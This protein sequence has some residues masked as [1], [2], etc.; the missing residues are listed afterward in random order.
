MSFAA[1]QFSEGELR[2]IDQRLLP[3]EQHWLSLHALEEVAIAIENMTVRGAPAIG[4]AAAFAVAMQARSLSKDS[5]TLKEQGPILMQGIERLKRTRPT[6]V[7]LFTALARMERVLGEIENT[8]P[9]SQALKA[10]ERAAQQ[11]FDDDLATCQAIGRWGASYINH[12]RPLHIITHCNTGSLATAGYGTALGIIRSLHAQGRVAMVYADE[13]RPWLQGARLTAFELEAE[14]IPYR[15]IADSAAAF[16][17]QTRPID[18]VVVGADRIAMNGDT[19]NKIGTYSL[20]VNARRHGIPFVVAAPRT[21][22]DRH[23]DS[24]REI[25]VEERAADEIKAVAGRYHAPR[26]AEVWNPSFDITPAEL[27]SAIVTEVGIA[28]APLAAALNRLMA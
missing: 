3:S 6:A 10:L 20:A 4:C 2:L 19:A 12:T 16:L 27:I 13:T 25:P 24:G 23:I 26:Q 1:M 5:T 14:G 9:M 28:E 15:L 18:L 7:N 8:A 17:M 11:I 21:T 22:I